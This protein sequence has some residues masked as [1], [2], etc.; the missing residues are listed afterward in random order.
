MP[1]GESKN[2]VRFIITL[3][4]FFALY[5]K[6][7]T[8]ISLNTF[9]I[10][11]LKERLTKEDFIKLQSKIKLIADDGHPFMASGSDGNMF[12]YGRGSNSYNA[13]NKNTLDWLDIKGPDYYD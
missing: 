13:D 10:E 9:F 5:G 11:E 8:I 12:V 2:W 1:N 3:S 4:S 6:Y 7:P